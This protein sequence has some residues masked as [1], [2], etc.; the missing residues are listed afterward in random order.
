M[1]ECMQ[2]LR[3]QI[4]E[5]LNRKHWTVTR[6]AVE[7]GIS[8]RE[9][10][11]ILSGKKKGICLSTLVQISE[12]TGIPIACLISAKEAQNHEDKMFIQRLNIQIGN[13]VKKG[14]IKA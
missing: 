3:E 10:N 13:Y 4:L 9:I 7:C 1:E 2:V 8:T 14:G 5:V 11:L 6:L 12:G